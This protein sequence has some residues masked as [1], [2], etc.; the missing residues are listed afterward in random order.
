MKLH[1]LTVADSVLWT[2]EAR[3]FVLLKTLGKNFIFVTWGLNKGFSG[4]KELEVSMSSFFSWW[5]GLCY[6]SLHALHGFKEW[7]LFP[8]TPCAKMQV[9]KTNHLL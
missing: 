3:T 1:D 4:E 2:Q 8:A 5:L 6:C 7:E 9:Y